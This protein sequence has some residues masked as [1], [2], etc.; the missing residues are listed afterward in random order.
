[1]DLRTL[2]PGDIVRHFKRE[3]VDPDSTKYLYR[4]IG[5]ATHSET[6][7]P[8]MVYQA[9]YD[10]FGMYV[11]PYEMFMSE[12]DHEKYPDIKQKYRFEKTELSE[13]EITKIGNPAKP[14]M[15]EGAQ[16]LDRMNKSHY[17]VTG[18][19]LD[20]FNFCPDDHVLDI[21]CGGGMTLKR[22]SEKVPKGHLTGVD[23]SPV[24]VEKSSETN[25]EDI[26]SGKMEILEASVSALPLPDD[27]FDRIIT[28]ESF[29]FWPE[30]VHDLSEVRRVLKPGGQFLLVADIYGSFDLDEKTRKNIRDL[31]LLNPTPDEF[32]D[33]FRSAGFTAV[34]VHL[35]EGTSWIAVEGRI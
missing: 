22:M 15:T 10:D 26:A 1:M 2:N 19:A 30:P 11:R 6:R 34:T 35:N 8:V 9:L 4:I 32:V 21:G 31:E 16:M 12:V 13:S 3:T 14:Q 17:E 28:V 33:L 29:Y 5:T 18:W 27:S 7:E 24:S 20:F 25:K 23:Y